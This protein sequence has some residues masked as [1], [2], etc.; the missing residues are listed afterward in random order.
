QGQIEDPARGARN[1]RSSELS[2]RRL[3]DRLYDDTA[4]TQLVHDHGGTSARGGDHADAFGC[5]GSG[6]QG[7]LARQR[8]NLKQRLEHFDP[9][10]A[11][12]LQE[13]VGNIVFTSQG[14]RMRGSHFRCGFRTAQLVGNHG[15]TALG[16]L[17]GER[18]QLGAV[19]HALEEQYVSFDFRIVQRGGADLSNA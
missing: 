19:T 16:G 2:L 4:Y 12:V 11:Q 6:A 10:D 14:A 3:G 9:H 5:A 13:G 17:S 15:F 1:L 8:Q 7:Q 18:L